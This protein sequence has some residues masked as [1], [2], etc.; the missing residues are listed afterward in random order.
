M[1][2][3]ATAAPAGKRVLVVDDDYYFRIVLE[4]TLT[5]NL[6]QAQ[7]AENAKHAQQMIG[8]DHFDLVISDIRMPDMTGVQLLHWIKATR[9]MPVILMTGFSEIAETCEAA[10]LGADGFLAKPFKREDLLQVIE[11]CFPVADEKVET[12]DLD[13]EFCKISVDD[14]ISGKEMKFDI[15]VRMT[16]S[17]YIKVAH[18]GEDIA[19]DRIQSYKSKNI[20]FLYMKKEDFRKYLNFNLSLAKVVT[21]SQKINHTKKVNFLKHTSE[22]MLQS[23]YTSEINSEDF[24]QAQSLVEN[25]VSLLSDNSD[26]VDL[27]STLSSHSDFLYAHCV[28]VSLYASLIGKAMGWSS[29]TTVI[30]L[31]LGGLLHDIGKKEISR[32]TLEKPRKDMTP[33]EIAL[34]ESHPT[35]GAEILAQLQC[36]PTDILQIT[37]EHHENCVGLGYP[38]RLKKSKIHPLARVVAVANEFCNLVIKNPNSPGLKPA[39]A[40][41]RMLSLHPEYYD[42]APLRALMQIFKIPGSVFGDLADDPDKIRKAG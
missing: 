11:S 6:Y 13:P 29:P 40:I 1:S 14:F 15:Y 36:I 28:A 16:E 39:E 17:K 20:Q 9:P 2:K 24:L 19:P 31:S 34:F 18:S 26:A 21:K 12:K 25:A 10:Q 8:L 27:L 3:K 42:E 38:M 35:R 33:E 41:Q 4:K 37:H 32:E 5:Q 7:C 30:K 22:V 23:L